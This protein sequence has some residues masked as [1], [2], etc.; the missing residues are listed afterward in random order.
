VKKRVI[1]I[2]D[3]LFA[4]AE[5]LAKYQEK[6]RSKLYSDALAEYLE[7]H[8]DNAVTESINRVVNDPEAA[9]PELDAF[10]AEAAR[11]TLMRN[12]WDD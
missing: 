10:V 1:S 9:D 7:R 6:T 11:Q 4:R 5:L 8:F 3:R 12:E 2:P